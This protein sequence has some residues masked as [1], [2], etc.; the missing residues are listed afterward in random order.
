MGDPESSMTQVISAEY[1]RDLMEQNVDL[2]GNPVSNPSAKKRKKSK[3]DSSDSD[4]TDSDSTSKRKK[5]KRRKKKD[6]K[7]DKDRESR[8]KDKSS[9]SRNKEKDSNEPRRDY[10]SLQYSKQ[11]VPRNHPKTRESSSEPERDGPVFPVDLSRNTVRESRYREESE[12]RR[13]LEK[14]E[15][16]RKSSGDKK[17]QTRD[18]TPESSYHS[19]G[20]LESDSDLESNGLD[21]KY[22]LEPLIHHLHL[23]RELF[24]K[25][26]FK[27]IRGRRRRHLLPKIL[28]DMPDKELKLNCLT[29]LATWSNKRLRVLMRTGDLMS[30]EAKGALIDPKQIFEEMQKRDEQATIREQKRLE[31]IEKGLEP[32]PETEE[33]PADT[34][35]DKAGSESEEEDIEAMRANLE[36][37]R[38]A[39][40][41]EE[42]L[43]L[44]NKHKLENEQLAKDLEEE[45]DLLNKQ[46][47]DKEKAKKKLDELNEKMA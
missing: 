8:S 44:R 38:E 12:E 28:R 21:L 19:P 26:I 4:S 41:E 3:K 10:P 15:K 32:E 31:A 30:A 16:K 22:D 7:R 43:K 47:E 17:K 36:K 6:K 14:N 27:I 33:L 20:N 1:K 25:Q 45:M 9:H 18:P 37:W 34:V 5:K 29:E 11:E 35:D 46:R 24:N 2:F 39:K 23:D 40:F 42:L 13:R